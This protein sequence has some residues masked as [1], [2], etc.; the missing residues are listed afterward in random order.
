[1]NNDVI[2]TLE[3]NQQLFKIDP[4]L[5]HQNSKFSSLYRLKKNISLDESLT[6]WMCRLGFK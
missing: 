1:M 3:E 4:I 6:L 5:E 2:E